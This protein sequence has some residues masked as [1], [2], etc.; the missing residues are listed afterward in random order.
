MND[1]M[2]YD[3]T[4]R[5]ENQEAGSFRNFQDEYQKCPLARGNQEVRRLIQDGP[6]FLQE[7]AFVGDFCIGLQLRL[8]I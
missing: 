2:R 1:L 8:A 4:I 6:C 5:S 7:S 3:Y